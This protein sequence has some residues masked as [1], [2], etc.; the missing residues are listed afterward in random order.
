[1]NVQFLS[2]RELKDLQEKVSA[3]WGR[4]ELPELDVVKQ[5]EVDE[6]RSALLGGHRLVSVKGQ[7][8]PFLGDEALCSRFPYVVVDMGSISYLA[9]G[10][11]VMRPGI[12]SFP[13]SFEKGDT[14]VVKD[15]RHLKGIAACTALVSSEEAKAMAK[16]AVLKNHHYAGDAFWA[17]FRDVG[18]S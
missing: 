18:V 15:E 14:V 9:N 4:V 2:K 10:A 7:V 3:A 13:S 11:N 16:G 5:I 17:V 1:M 8:L 6:D 12:K